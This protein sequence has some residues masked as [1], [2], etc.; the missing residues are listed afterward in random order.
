MK[1]AYLLAAAFTAAGL[2]AFAQG[3]GSQDAEALIRQADANGDGNITK[4]EFLA[5]RSDAFKDLDT[6]A[7]GGL[8]ESEF[9]HAVSKRVKRFSGRAFAMVD[10]DGN[11]TVSQA[12][13]DQNPPRAFNK[14]DRNSDGILTPSERKRIE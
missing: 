4:D 5:R 7:S 9:E 10:T 6:D 3:A 1:Y 14:L 13:W 12:E 8:T 2:P 11:G